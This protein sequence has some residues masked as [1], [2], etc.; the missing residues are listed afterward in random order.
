MGAACFRAHS[1]SIMSGGIIMSKGIIIKDDITKI[2]DRGE[3]EFLR[4]LYVD[5]D[6]LIRG[7]SSYKDSIPGDLDSGVAFAEVMP[8]FS[9][10]DNIAPGSAIGC[11]GELRA[12]PDI[13]TFRMLPY[14]KGQGQIICDFKTR[15]HEESE[16]CAR[17]ALKKILE[18]CPYKVFSSFENEY[19]YALRKDDGTYIPFDKSLCFA[20][21][22][23]QS[24]E[25]IIKETAQ[26]L[27]EQGMHV[28][29]YYPEYGPGQQELVIRY[30]E[31]MQAADNQVLY[32]ETVR[33]VAAKHNAIASFMPKPFQGLAGSG[34]HLHVSLW[35]GDQNLF[36]DQNNKY[37]LSDTAL[38]FIGGVLDH[39]A[40]LCA[41]TASIV[42]SYKRLVPHNW[43]SAYACYGLD[44]REAA[45]RVCSGQKG[46]EALT[47]NLEF[48]PIDGACNPYLA[49]T[50]LL[51]AGLDGINRKLDPGDAV[52]IDPDNY[53]D[54][55]K[56]ARNIRRLPT[57]LYEA[58]KALENDRFFIDYFGEALIKEYLAMK[59]YQWNEYHAQVTP[60]EIDRY[61]EIY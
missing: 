30:T 57:N 17:T 14:A 35:N 46:R 42:T 20:T 29:K 26:A 59:K 32:R 1:L 43:A 5:N 51:A 8:V 36:Y 15:N 11:T 56:A 50:A 55:E 33:A 24:T 53:S 48:K 47:T 44:N 25:E 10:L 37:N 3:L 38:Y 21:Q 4:F 39:I 45:L 2:V 18:K 19:Y 28:E 12:V 34:C 13:S 27:T 7:Y 40:A 52:M 54:E 49:L 31:A 58:T 6:G 41:F 61:L 60:W 22:G 16:L 9:A 23:M